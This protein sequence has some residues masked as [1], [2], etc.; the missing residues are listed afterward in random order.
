MR[1]PEAQTEY[2]RLNADIIDTHVHMRG[3]KERYKTSPDQVILE[4]FSSGITISIAMPNT[5]PS[6]DSYHLGV[7]YALQAGSHPRVVSST[8]PHRLQKLYIG[9]TD[10]NFDEV[11]RFLHTPFAA[12]IKIYPS[13]EVTTGKLGVVKD[14]S[15]LRHMV[16]AVEANKVLAVHCADP[17]IFKEKGCD[18]IEGEIKYLEKI[19]DLA[20]ILRRQLKLVICHVSCRTSVELILRAQRNGYKNLFIELA[21]HYLWFDSAGTNWKPGLDPAFYKCFNSLRGPEEREYLVSLLGRKDIK[22]II[23]GSD[24]ADHTTQEKLSSNPPGGIPSNQELVPV[25]ITLAKQHGISEKRVADLIC[26][27]AARLFGIEVSKE[28]VKY[29]IEKQVDNLQYNNGAVTNP[30]NGSELYFPIERIG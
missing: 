19:L 5:R 30:W 18:T 3:W 14:S 21:P 22:N 26:F 1:V 17:T 12:G 15:I 8:F 7:K 2:F 29:R 11:G 9:A 25:M 20:Y 10:E 24:R 16:S 28:M 6:I 27:N 13:G 4:G 23:I